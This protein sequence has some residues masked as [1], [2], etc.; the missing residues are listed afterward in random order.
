MKADSPIYEFPIDVFQ[1][2]DVNASR[3]GEFLRQQK[4]SMS[5]EFMAFMKKPFPGP[6]LIEVDPSGTDKVVASE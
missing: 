4:K 6:R 3:F 5:P 1:K 2:Y